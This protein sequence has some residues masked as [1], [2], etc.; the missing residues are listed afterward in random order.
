MYFATSEL[1]SGSKRLG[2]GGRP[3]AHTALA[4]ASAPEWDTTPA[5]YPV[6]A[7]RTLHGGGNARLKPGQLSGMGVEGSRLGS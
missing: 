1:H 6:T 5:H 7:R 3:Q 4:H 2:K